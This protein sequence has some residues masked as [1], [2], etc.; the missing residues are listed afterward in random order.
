MKKIYSIIC[1]MTVLCVFACKGDEVTIVTVQPE[2]SVIPYPIKLNES[3]SVIFSCPGKGIVK[4]EVTNTGEQTENAITKISIDDKDIVSVKDNELPK[5]GEI[6][7]GKGTHKA[8]AVF[9]P[10]EIG[11]GINVQAEGTTYINVME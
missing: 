4:Y 10:V 2:P 11:G 5:I 6:Y 3:R 7:V 1:L 8:T 9:G